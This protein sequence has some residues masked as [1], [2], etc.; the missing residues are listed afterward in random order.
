MGGSGRQLR[1]V[2][3]DRLQTHRQMASGSRVG[4]RGEPDGSARQT[5]TVYV[6]L[7]GTSDTGRGYEPVHSR[8]MR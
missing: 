8:E 5:G 1:A 4:L 3:T 2:R 7:L 6:A